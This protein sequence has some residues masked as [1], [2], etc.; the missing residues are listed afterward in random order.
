MADLEAQ[1]LCKQLGRLGG[2]GA[3]WVARLLPS[4]PHEQRIHL[5][6]SSVKAL[7]AIATVFSRIGKSIPEF[8]PTPSGF[9]M[10]TGSGHQDMN[11][12]L[13][14]AQVEQTPQ[15]CNIVI[16][17]VAKEGAVKQHSAQRAVAKVEAALLAEFTGAP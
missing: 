13:V 3:R 12:T 15:G 14:H 5:N 17:A 7:T 4:V 10:I 9:S 6:V 11:P 8:P 16:R 1:I 2:F